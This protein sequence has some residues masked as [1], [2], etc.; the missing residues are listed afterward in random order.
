MLYLSSTTGENTSGISTANSHSTFKLEHKHRATAIGETRHRG[1]ISKLH[2]KYWISV[3]MSL[4][5]LSQTFTIVRVEHEY[6]AKCVSYQ[7]SIASFIKKI[8][9][10]KI[11]LLGEHLNK[12]FNK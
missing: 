10:K 12:I 9:I 6:V 4:G 5:D 2:V 7:Q 8:D 11:G 3:R 1:I